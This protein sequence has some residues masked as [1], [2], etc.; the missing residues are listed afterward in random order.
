VPRIAFLTSLAV[1]AAGCGGGDSRS[2]VNAE[3]R[4]LPNGDARGATIVSGSGC[5]ACHR[6]GEEGADGPGPDLTTVGAR[7]SD[8]EIRETLIAG[9]APMPSYKG[10][11]GRDLGALVDY[12]AGLR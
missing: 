8:D 10:L 11:P 6:F 2:A 12:L 9:E 3:P 1:L 7:L 5:L 4:D